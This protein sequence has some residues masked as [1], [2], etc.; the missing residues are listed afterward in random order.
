M[1]DLVPGITS[2]QHQSKKDVDGR[3]EARHDEKRIIF[4]LLG[5]A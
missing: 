5:A 2:Q 1:P 4:K 3:D